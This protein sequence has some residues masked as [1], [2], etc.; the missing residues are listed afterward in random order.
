M[1]SF[2]MIATV[3]AFCRTCGAASRGVR[4]SLGAILAVATLLPGCAS[5]KAATMV[6]GP[7]LAVPKAPERVVVPAEEEPLAATSV[8]PDTPVAS[9]PR[10]QPSPL[11]TRRPATRTEGDTRTDATQGATN[12]ATA[13]GPAADAKPELRM[14]PTSAQA[15]A[16]EGRVRE[17]LSK[18]E[19]DRKKV[20]QLRLSQTETNNLGESKRFSERAVKALQEGNVPFAKNLAEKAAELAAALA[21]R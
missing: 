8:G 1:P 13:L 4:L 18:A 7:P 6:E 21:A 19:A 20:E 11:P 2:S 17:L 15:V 5:T 16:D 9:V 14:V 10:V 3:D 12:S